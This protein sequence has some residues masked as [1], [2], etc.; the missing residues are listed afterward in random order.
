MKNIITSLLLLGCI[1]SSSAH[2]EDWNQPTVTSLYQ[3]V[4]TILKAR[5]KSA[6]TMDYP[7]ATNLPADVIRWN[8][9]NKT[10]EQWNGSAWS[11]THPELSSHLVSTSNPHNVTTG[12]IGAASTASLSAHTSNTSN[13]HGTTTGQIGALAASSN[14]SDLTNTATARSNLS[15][16]S[17]SDLSAHTSN[18]SNPH[19]VTTAQ[20]GA[21]RK[22]NNLADLAN[23]VTARTNLNA[24]RAGDNTDITSITGVTLLD[25]NG[26]DI[27]IKTNHFGS[28]VKFRPSGDSGAE[29]KLQYTGKWLP[30]ASMR[31]DYTPWPSGSGGYT[32]RRTLDPS[33]ATAR[34]CA[35][36]INTLYADLIE[37]GLLQ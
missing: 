2:A 1:A 4:L 25:S 28:G 37:Q 35:D 8:R 9:Y 34:T 17:S 13:P 12:Q 18:T 32:V 29:W 20:I 15:V 7:S 3:D 22:D 31:H 33:A 5:D 21:A 14:L 26:G 36:A 23:L 11:N 6:A 27:L 10:F 19:G 24:A 16:P 30:P